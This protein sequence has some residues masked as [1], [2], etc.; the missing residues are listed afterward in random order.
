MRALLCCDKL[1]ALL[2]KDWPHKYIEETAYLRALLTLLFAYI[3]FSVLLRLI[4]LCGL[5]AHVQN[6]K[7]MLALI[8]RLRFDARRTR[9]LT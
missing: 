8:A 1:H 3:A 2:L 7:G 4:A 9:L 5:L 6:Y